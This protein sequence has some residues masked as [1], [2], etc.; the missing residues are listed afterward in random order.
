MSCT[1][2]LFRVATGSQNTNTI[3]VLRSI[4]LYA[5]HQEWPLSSRPQLEDRSIEYP[6]GSNSAEGGQAGW[7]ATLKFT[8]LQDLANSLVKGVQLPEPAQEKFGDRWEEPI[9]RG[10][11]KRLAIMAD[12]DQAGE[13]YANGK[14]FYPVTAKPNKLGNSEPVAL[15]H[16]L[17]HTIGLYTMPS[18]STIL[19]MGCLAGQGPDGT[20][21]LTALSEIWPGRRVVGFDVLGSVQV[22][23]MRDAKAKALHAGMKLT[24]F[25]SGFEYKAREQHNDAEIGRRWD[26]LEWASEF[27]REHAKIVKDGKVLQC[28]TGEICPVPQAPSPSQ[29][30]HS[31]KP[32]RPSHPMRSHK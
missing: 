23:K 22:G 26:T 16:E 10:E 14:T 32:R 19:L 15:F 4:N 25:R 30:A 8:S 3:A 18:K 2:K 9:G 11:I 21:L 27:S 7:D 29:P 12:G 1:T 31:D 5:Y 20:D 13:W 17:L 24:W 6:N 28:P